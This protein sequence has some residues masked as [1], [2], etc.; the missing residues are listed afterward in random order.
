MVVRL[1]F[2]IL[3]SLPFCIGEVVGT[4]EMCIEECEVGEFFTPQ[5]VECILSAECNQESIFRCFE[6]G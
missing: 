1:L 4:V 2:N 6:E 5:R 3:G